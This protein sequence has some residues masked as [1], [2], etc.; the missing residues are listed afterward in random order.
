M[1]TY[2]IEFPDDDVDYDPSDDDD[3]GAAVFWEHHN[4]TWHNGEDCDGSCESDETDSFYNP[5]SKKLDKRKIRR[6]KRITGK[7]KKLF[8]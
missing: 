7:A 1:N 3:G 5:K 6:I 8:V 2:M 4:A